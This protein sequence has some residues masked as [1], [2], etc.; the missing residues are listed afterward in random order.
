MNLKEMFFSR[1]TLCAAFFSLTSGAFAQQSNDSLLYDVVEESC[2]NRAF[3]PR[4]SLGLSAEMTIVAGSKQFA[5]YYVASNRHGQ[6]TQS[7]DAFIRLDAISPM[8]DSCRWDYGF[9]AS[10]IGGYASAVD[11]SQYD[12][13][14]NSVQQFSR[15]PSWM[16][17][18][19]LYGE[20]RYRRVFLEV[21]LRE[22]NSALLSHILSSGDLVE[23]GNARP[24]PQVRVGF[25]RFV[26]IPF[27][28]GWL[29]LQGIVSYGKFMD[30]GWMKDHYNYTNWHI[31][32][33]GLYTYKRCYFRTNPSQ[34]LSVTFGMQTA[35]M[36]GG[37]TSYYQNGNLVM[38][39]KWSRSL[40]TFF[41]MFF[42]TRGVGSDYYEGNSLGSW[43]IMAR[44]RLS[45]GDELHAYLQKPFEDGSGIGWQNGF[46]GL[47]GL[48]YKSA[49]PLKLVN[50]AVVEYLDFTNQ[51][52]PIHWAPG[53]FPG[54][55]LTSEATGGD[56]YYN[57]FMSNAYMNYGMS[58]GTPFL[59]SPIYNT[60][61]YMAF[62]HNRIRGFHSGIS[63]CF[64]PQF[65]YRLLG[66]YR[67]G[68]GDGRIPVVN[69]AHDTS[70]M[71]EGHYHPKW[72][73]SIDFKLQLAWDN[74]NMYKSG[75][76]TAL[77]I[78]YRIMELK[79]GQFVK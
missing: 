31:N 9:G 68:W 15:H 41:K 58:I 72:M 37:T 6:I 63:G 8:S 55:D 67:K 75:L 3:S 13:S 57:N 71:L 30:N 79:Y 69:A 2:S 21:G 4:H 10:V 1:A 12:F 17:L 14:T 26:D 24:I 62:V 7:K 44:W 53:D 18:Q 47:W 34:P 66:S 38:S 76:A 40:K 61:G 78:V 22:H 35:G 42:P 27:T 46:D 20:I 33:G 43:D 28:N 51:S 36:F 77:T 32:L 60:D 29:Q 23:S 64:T 70:V 39:H 19:Q 52:G 56:M 65:G 48:E 74:G 73:N 16:M 5:P 54:T 49:N 50:G 59:P 25:D 45:N 11:Y